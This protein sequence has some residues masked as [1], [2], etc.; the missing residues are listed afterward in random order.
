MNKFIDSKIKRELLF[1]VGAIVLIVLMTIISV[2]KTHQ[3]EDLALLQIDFTNTVIK[4][5]KCFEN[6]GIVQD[7]SQGQEGKVFICSNQETVGDIFPILKKLSRRGLGYK[8][9]S[10]E[11]CFDRKCI[12]RGQD[13]NKGGRINIGRGNR[14]ILSCN[15]ANGVCQGR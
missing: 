12:Q 5:K 3:R 7:P 13:N 6:N 8:Y 11:K 1:G 9:L 4:A 10:S 2:R 14:L 15:V